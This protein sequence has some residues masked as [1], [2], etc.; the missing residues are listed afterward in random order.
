MEECLAPT[1]NF[2][3]ER[4]MTDMIGYAFQLYAIFVANS[5]TLSPN[6]QL[7][8]NSILSNKD[9]WE[10]D[11]KYLIPAL[12]NYLVAMI[13]KYPDQFTSGA[14]LTSL[15]EIVSH[16]MKHDV[17]MEPTAM[18]LAGAMFEKLTAPE[19]F[20]KGFLLAVFHCMHFYRNNTKSKLIPLAITKA[21]WSCLATFAIY[22]GLQS[23]YAACDSI[24]PQIF[25]MVLK[26]EGDKLKHVTMTPRERKYTIVAFSQIM[27]DA[28]TDVVEIV[29]KSLLE[30]C[31]SQ[32]TGFQL[33]SSVTTNTEDLLVDGAIDQTFAFQRSEYIQLNAAKVEVSDK[34]AQEIPS[35]EAFFLS[36]L[37][38]LAQART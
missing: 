13:Y 15:Q 28:P 5:T 24:Q 12:A 9:N 23:L 36:S 17:R 19:A 35:P 11:M 16:L 22:Q 34:L 20:A 27:A 1:L 3:M 18:T 14:G 2:I 33:A 37:T 31:C 21:V 7:L 8:A 25:F 38:Q 4:N 32:N 30:L 10:K 29:A 6:Y 26:S